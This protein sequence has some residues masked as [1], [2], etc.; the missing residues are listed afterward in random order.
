MKTDSSRIYVSHVSGAA[1][2]PCQSCAVLNIVLNCS[3]DSDLHRKLGYSHTRFPLTKC[4]KFLSSILIHGLSH[5]NVVALSNT[6]KI[7]MFLKKFNYE[8]VCECDGYLPAS[9]IFMETKRK[10]WIMEMKLQTVG[11]YPKSVLRIELRFSGSIE[12]ILYY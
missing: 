4:G 9:V 7:I 8:Y 10:C 1:G 3:C 2:K 12:P 5:E 6:L 11:S